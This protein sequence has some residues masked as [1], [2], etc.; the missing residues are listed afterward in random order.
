M[1]LIYDFRPDLGYTDADFDEMVGLYKEDWGTLP[2]GTGRHP[3]RAF[4]IHKAIGMAR[5][6]NEPDLDMTVTEARIKE[7]VEKDAEY[8]YDPKKKRWN[9]IG[10]DP[11]QSRLARLNRRP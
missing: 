3:A 1:H 5:F 9:L 4:A 7:F 8:E 6:A 11:K 2:A 10:F